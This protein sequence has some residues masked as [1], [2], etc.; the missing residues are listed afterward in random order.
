LIIICNIVDGLIQVTKNEGFLKLYVGLIPSLWLVSHGAIQFL[1][2]D[3]LKYFFA[4]KNR[5][6]VN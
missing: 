1:V 6:F 5:Q 3:K 2:Y 4:E